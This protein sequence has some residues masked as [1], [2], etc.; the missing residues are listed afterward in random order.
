MLIFS[1][2][3]CLLARQEPERRRCQGFDI[4]TQTIRKVIAF[5]AY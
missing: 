4:A 2:A 3:L 5:T 1:H